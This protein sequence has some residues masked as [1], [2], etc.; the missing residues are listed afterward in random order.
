MSKVWKYR[1]NA[2]GDLM[3]ILVEDGEEVVKKEL[4]PI[5]LM[6]LGYER[7]NQKREVK[8][9]EAAKAQPP[10]IPL[11]AGEKEPDSLTL[12]RLGYQM[13]EEARRMDK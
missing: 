6:A 10:I 3:K 8:E 7:L 12:I 13:A 11:K 2:N 5:E 9:K 4:T 1:A